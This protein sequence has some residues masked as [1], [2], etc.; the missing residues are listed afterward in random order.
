MF[1]TQLDLI[2]EDIMLLDTHFA[3][4]VWIGKM[5]NNEYQRLSIKMALD[6]LQEGK[7]LKKT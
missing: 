5:C 7:N 3:L 2:P 1:F 4:Y 6:Y